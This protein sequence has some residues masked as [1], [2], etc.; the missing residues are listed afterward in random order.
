[1]LHQIFSSLLAAFVIV[2]AVLLPAPPVLAAPAPPAD[3]WLV[4]LYEDADDEVLEKDTF[5]DLNESELVGSTPKVT[6]VAQIDRYKGGGSSDGNDFRGDGDWTGTRRY[7]VQK[8]P[9]G[10]MTRI[11][12]KLVSDLG[13]VDMGDPNTLIDFVQWAIRT[14]PAARH[15]LIMAILLPRTPRIWSSLR[16][17]RSRS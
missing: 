4:L 12:S 8:D 9:K 14:Y 13:E 5:I 3:T 7:L 2:T 16:A 6:I 10:D 1:M 17:S 15:A 11:V